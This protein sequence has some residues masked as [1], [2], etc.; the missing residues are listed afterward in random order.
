MPKLK[1]GDK[2]IITKEIAEAKKRSSANAPVDEFIGKE[3]T[4]NVVG[5]TTYSA[6]GF[7]FVFNVVD[8]NLVTNNKK[9]LKCTWEISFKSSDGIEIKD[10]EVTIK[11]EAGGNGCKSACSIGFTPDQL[12]ALANQIRAAK[13]QLK[14]LK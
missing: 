1:V 3:V 8:K 12:T 13:L 14:K 10:G 4:V 7:A 6:W 11:F 5:A 9:S 2:F